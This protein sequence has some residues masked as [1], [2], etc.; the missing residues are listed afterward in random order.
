MRW[1]AA[2]LAAVALA[3]CGGDGTGAACTQDTDCSGGQVCARNEQCDAKSDVRSVKITWTIGG[4]PASSQTCAGQPSLYLQFDSPY[5]GDD[6]GFDPVPCQQGQ[7]NIDK[8]P[9]RFDDV[10]LGPDGG[11]LLE[12]P[13]DPADDPVSFDLMP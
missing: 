1:L 7:F 3:G 6:F 10:E 9:K 2:L 12:A 8:L 13:I 5:Y 11:A 4:M